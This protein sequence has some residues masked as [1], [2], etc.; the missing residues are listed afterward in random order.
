MYLSTISDAINRHDQYGILRV[1]AFQ[2]FVVSVCIFL[3]NF[4]FSP[5]YMQQLM[6]MFFVGL[7]GAATSPSFVRRQL[8]VIT[9]TVIIAIWL[10]AT[11]LVIKHNAASVLL[12][13]FLISLT[14]LLGKKIPLLGG[15]AVTFFMADAMLPQISP[16]G[17][18]YAYYNFIVMTAIFL[19]LVI[20]FMNF[21][22]K[23]YY[24]RIW[25]RAYCLCLKELASAM[26]ALAN[27]EMDARSL[28]HIP[29]LYRIT[30]GLSKRENNF[31]TRKVNI[32]LLRIYK[33][34]TSMR[35][36]LLPLNTLQLLEMANI[37]DEL[38][39]KISDGLPLSQI[40]ANTTNL[41]AKIYYA[42][43]QLILQWNKLC[44]VV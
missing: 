6:P 39:Q 16:S 22:P 25:V 12:T 1:N 21:F 17:S 18:L 37:F 20:V 15:L 9:V 7:V 31:A 40:P 11:S 8:I 14:F 36:D 34:F 4:I 5:P 19:L 3:V 13:G 30:A 23:V 44:S 28:K 32:L 24:L 38:Y 43:Q 2:S 42:V 29:A 27:G 41:P 26:R 10:M 33:Y 35:M